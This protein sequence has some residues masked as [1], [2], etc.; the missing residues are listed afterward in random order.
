[1][2]EVREKVHEDIQKRCGEMKVL[3]RDFSIK[4]NDIYTRVYILKGISASKHIDCSKM[5]E[6]VNRENFDRIGLSPRLDERRIPGIEA[7]ELYDKLMVW[8]QP[9]SGKTTFLKYLAIQ[10]DGDE[11]Q[12]GRVP[13]FVPLEDF[14]EADGQPDLLIYIQK[15]YRLDET[16]VVQLLEQG[17]VLVL[18]DGL[19]QVRTAHSQRF[20]RQ[21]KDFFEQYHHNKF[22]MTCRR[23]AAQDYRFEGFGDVEV[24]DFDEQQIDQFAHKWFKPDTNKADRF[25]LLLSEPEN[26]PVKELATNPLL[27][28]LLCL[29]FEESDSFPLRRSDLYEKGIDLLLKR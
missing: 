26:K 6:S 29:V 17:K 22:V 2:R 1:V 12:P 11:V 18:L 27:L 9:G 25:V 20:L 3:D 16:E 5:Q 24:A 8:G 28:T 19:D 7:V 14:A 21:I 15:H 4:V 23:I 13:I 10:C